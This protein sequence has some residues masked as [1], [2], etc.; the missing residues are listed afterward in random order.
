M[1]GGSAHANP[2]P[3]DVV[4]APRAEAARSSTARRAADR[5]LRCASFVAAALAFGASRAALPQASALAEEAPAEPAGLLPLRDYSGDVGARAYL[6]GDW[7]GSRTDL[8]DAGVQL[9]IDWTQTLQSVISGGR[10][11]GAAYAGTLDYALALDLMRM[12]VMPGALVKLRAETRYGASINGDSGSL[13]PVNTDAFF[14]LTDQLDEDVLLTV[15]TISYTQFLSPKLAFMAGKFDILD[16][17]PNEFASGRGTRQFMDA[18]FIFNAVTALR[19][20]YSTVGGGIIWVPLPAGPDGGVTVSS[21]IVATTDSSTTVGFDTLDDGLTW[22]AEADFQ[23][24]LGG[25]K[26]PGGQNLGFIY[27][28]D[29]DFTKIGSRLV[30]RPGEGFVIP[31]AG[32]TW[33]LYWSAWQYLR[34]QDPGDAP[35]NLLDGMPDHQ[36]L[37]LFARAGVADHDTNPVEWSASAGIGGRGAFGRPRDTYGAGYFYSS[38]QSTRF[39]GF[40]GVADHGHGFEAYYSLALTPATFLTL[41]AQVIDSPL[42]GTD[43]AV[44]LGARLRLVF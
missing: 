30:F 40:L 13:L 1:E 36:G 41:D 19:A 9:D 16:A 22:S 24:R 42:A 8:A 32:E 34:V 27:S 25:A 21:L 6:T 5:P 4:A 39:T 15:T 7:G 35:I 33:A 37:G 43:P 10:D 17:D 3:R 29:Q 12:G 11:T 20:P 28:F 18:N 26:L 23:Y 38:F 44:I 2:G 31:T 14:P